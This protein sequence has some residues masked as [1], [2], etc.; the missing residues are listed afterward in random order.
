MT[1]PH[2][3]LLDFQEAQDEVRL[4]GKDWEVRT[5]AYIGRVNE[6]SFWRV[7]FWQMDFEHL[8]PYLDIKP[9]AR[10]AALEKQEWVP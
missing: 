7:Y 8:A 4:L 2:D 9:V 6:D 1:Y 3:K 5:C 10:G